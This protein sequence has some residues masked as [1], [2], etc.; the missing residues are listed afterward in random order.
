MSFKLTKYITSKNVT[1]LKEMNKSI[2]AIEATSSLRY[3]NLSCSKNLNPTIKK[4]NSLKDNLL[5][6]YYQKLHRVISFKN[7]LI[8]EL[9]TT[10]DSLKIRLLVD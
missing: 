5:F 4:I 7:Y 8:I 1:L 10:F 9:K 3:K 2:K 6:N